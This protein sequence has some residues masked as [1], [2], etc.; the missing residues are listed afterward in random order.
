[1]PRSDYFA[2]AQRALKAIRSDEI[3]S[4]RFGTTVVSSQHRFLCHPDGAEC[5]DGCDASPNPERLAVF[6]EL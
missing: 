6:N 2:R 5:P 3:D 4:A 1:M